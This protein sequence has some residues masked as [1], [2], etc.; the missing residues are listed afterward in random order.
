MVPCHCKAAANSGLE[1]RKVLA[2]EG[3]VFNVFKHHRCFEGFSRRLGGWKSGPFHL[4]PVPRT[5]TTTVIIIIGVNISLCDDWFSH[6]PFGWLLSP[7]HS[8]QSPPRAIHVGSLISQIS[9]KVIVLQC[10]KTS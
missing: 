3:Q 1:T 5:T 10:R 6:T 9:T 4:A 2:L 8:A 7:I